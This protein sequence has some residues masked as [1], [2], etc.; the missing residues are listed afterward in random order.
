MK[1]GDLVTRIVQSCQKAKTAIKIV[2]PRDLACKT[3]LLAWIQ[4]AS[5]K[6]YTKIVPND[7]GLDY[8]SWAEIKQPTQSE[9]LCS[10]NLKNKASTIGHLIMWSGFNQQCNMNIIS[11]LESI[12]LIISEARLCQNEGE[13]WD[14]IAA[15]ALS[16]RATVTYACKIVSS[17]KTKWENCDISIM[18][19]NILLEACYLTH[20]VGSTFSPAFNDYI[21]KSLKAA[22]GRPNVVGVVNMF[23]QHLLRGNHIVPIQTPLSEMLYSSNFN[24]SQIGLDWFLKLYATQKS[25]KDKD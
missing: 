12:Q 23:I 22:E 13:I 7:F 15:L 10:V 17:K 18:K 1:D 25:N 8:G 24:K 16:V 6:I 20:A 2:T 21:R 19:E 9:S 4:A 11:C 3:K 14:W 5:E